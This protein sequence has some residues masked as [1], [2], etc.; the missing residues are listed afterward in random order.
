MSKTTKIAVGGMMTALSVA[1]MFSSSLIPFMTYAIPAMAG[2]L[3]LAIVDIFGEKWAW[4]IYG[5]TGF[6]SLLLVVDKE[7]GVMY[8]AFF[9]FY[10][11]VKGKLE[12]MRS[13]VIRWLVKF[14]IFNVAMVCAELIVVYVLLIPIE[15]MLSG[16]KWAF[17]GLIALVNVMFLIYDFALT[18]VLRVYNKIWRPKVKQMFR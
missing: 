2:A 1:L 13:P 8:T 18:Q 11:I 15:E 6:L 17:I 7:A 12:L 10:P 16:G 4:L 14:S 9:G 5:A 3:L